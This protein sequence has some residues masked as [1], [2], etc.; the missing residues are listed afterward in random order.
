MPN[1]EIAIRGTEHPSAH[2][3]IQHL[4][5]SGDDHA[6][7]V[8]NK[9]LTLKHSEVERIAAAGIEFAYLVDHDGQIMTIPVNDQ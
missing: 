4:E 1:N 7:L 8:D 3:A 9:Y 2:E 6:I 5:V